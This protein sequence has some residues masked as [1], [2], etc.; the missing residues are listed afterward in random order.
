MN[1]LPEIATRWQALAGW[2]QQRGEQDVCPFRFPDV[3]RVAEELSLP[4]ICTAGIHCAPGDGLPAQEPALQ[5]VDQKLLRSLQYALHGNPPD[6]RA[7]AWIEQLLRD[8]ELKRAELKQLCQ[9]S[10]QSPAVAAQCAHWL[11]LLFLEYFQ[12]YQDPRC[13]NLVLKLLDEKW[14]APAITGKEPA[15]NGPA[16]LAAVKNGRAT[17]G[18]VSKVPV[19][20]VAIRAWPDVLEL[21]VRAL[22]AH[23][24]QVMGRDRWQAP[25]RSIC[26]D[27]LLSAPRLP[28]TPQFTTAQAPG[29]VVLSPSRYCLQ[30]LAVLQL[31]DIHGVRV[32]GIAACRPASSRRFRRDY[33][34]D[35]GRLLQ[36]VWE[37]LGLPE[38]AWSQR[39]YRTLHQL[40]TDIGAHQPHLSAWGKT[41]GTPIW[42]CDHFNDD[43]VLAALNAY[44]PRAVVLVGEGQIQG[45]MLT[46]AGAGVISTQ[47]GLLSAQ[48][49]QNVTEWSI[50]EG[51]L[52]QVGVT[53]NLLSDKGEAGGILAM[54]RAPCGDTED[55][56]QLRERMEELCPLACV[57]ATLQVL[58]GTLAPQPQCAAGRE[59][60][61]L[62]PRLYE[63]AR[64]RYQRLQ[65]A[66]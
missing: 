42:E 10:G 12:I 30:T 17:S 25:I 23:A 29:V 64:R 34:R 39:S 14:V 7:A 65:A 53:V 58:K 40:L 46:A 32:Q 22:L 26:E 50:L 3:G 48:R 59:Y 55:L 9:Q 47:I 15:K 49:G 19:E 1:E 56:P 33:R 6:P 43:V 38:Q 31:L 62:H 36:Q 35:A 8:C 66:Q 57:Q 18:E 60:F 44:R 41:H 16:K 24:L 45:P 28:M 52:G 63:L 11:C 51:H 20:A 61:D 5:H 37:K 54:Y 13:V 27:R 4:P 2:L 21:L